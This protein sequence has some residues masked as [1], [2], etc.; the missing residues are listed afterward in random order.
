MDEQNGESEEEE[1]MGVR[2]EGTGSRMRLT[3]R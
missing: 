2:N 1:V 3:K